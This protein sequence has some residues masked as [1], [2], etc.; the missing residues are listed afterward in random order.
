MAAEVLTIVFALFIFEWVGLTARRPS[1]TGF[2]KRDAT[3]LVR[4]GVV[5]FGASLVTTEEDRHVSRN[6]VTDWVDGRVHL[7][8]A[9]RT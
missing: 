2:G 8:A 3:R 9:S 1:S 5:I 6:E 7:S 4:R